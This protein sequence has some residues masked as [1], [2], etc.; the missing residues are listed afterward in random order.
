MSMNHTI[1]IAT[2]YLNNVEKDIAKCDPEHADLLA[3]QAFKLAQLLNELRQIEVQI[4]RD[5]VDL[6]QAVKKFHS[7]RRP[8]PS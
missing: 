5:Y 4:V 8:I 2:R 1:E 3:K 7:S 6:K